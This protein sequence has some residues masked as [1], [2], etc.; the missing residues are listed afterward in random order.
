MS[1]QQITVEVNQF[2]KLPSCKIKALEIILHH[3]AFHGFYLLWNGVVF[4]L[5]L[6]HSKKSIPAKS[7][8][9]LLCVCVF[10]HVQLFAPLT[11][12]DI[13]PPCFPSISYEFV[14]ICH[15]PSPIL[16]SVWDREV[17]KTVCTLKK[18]KV[19]GDLLV[20]NL[21]CRRHRFK[22]WLGN[23]NPTCHV[24][25]GPMRCNKRRL[26]TATK[27]QYSLN[28]LFL[29]V[30]ALPNVHGSTVYNSQDME[31]T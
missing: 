5:N 4:S 17:M 6:Y 1:S 26:H 30:G 9:S 23:Q 8:P 31:A 15:V 13:Y 25:T 7:I 19:P 11:Y 18:W 14:K 28:F 16:G 21:Q 10:N 20:K 22:A 27:T 3:K 24:A 29:K 12:A 2:T